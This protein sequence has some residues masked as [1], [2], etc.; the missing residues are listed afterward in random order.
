MMDLHDLPATI[1]VLDSEGY[2]TSREPR[3]PVASK[4]LEPPFTQDVVK[5]SANPDTRMQYSLVQEDNHELVSRLRMELERTESTCES[6]RGDLDIAEKSLAKLRHNFTYEVKLLQKTISDIQ[7]PK[8]TKKLGSERSVLKE[9]CRLLTEREKLLEAHEA[10][11]LTIKELKES[12]LNM[13]AQKQKRSSQPKSRVPS[14][15]PLRSSKQIL[16][17]TNESGAS[18]EAMCALAKR[19]SNLTVRSENMIFIEDAK[20]T[21]E[22]ESQSI[23]LSHTFALESFSNFEHG[24]SMHETRDVAIQARHID[25]GHALCQTERMGKD[26]SCDA[27]PIGDESINISQSSVDSAIDGAADHPI[28]NSDDT[29]VQYVRSSALEDSFINTTS[30]D[31]CIIE[32]E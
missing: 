4:S 12:Y 17:P 6:L 21:R 30:P 25:A 9:Y 31:S 32:N 19:T 20:P 14:T 10:D 2:K 5:E 7:H 1:T 11:K 24:R 29:A 27:V 16:C 22:R 15:S 23:P 13:L 8:E 18:P 3:E 28:Q 26:V